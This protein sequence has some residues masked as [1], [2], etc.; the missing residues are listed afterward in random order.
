MTSNIGSELIRSRISEAGPKAAEVADQVKGELLDLLRRSLRPEFLNR[1]DEIIVFHPLNK[2]HLKQILHLQISQLLKRLEKQQVGVKL[3]PAAEDYLIEV[4]TDPLFGARPL[5]R[6]LQREL[7]NP[8]AREI[9]AGAFAPGYVV[10]VDYKDGQLRFTK[11]VQAEVV[12]EEAKAEVVEE[13]TD[14]EED[15]S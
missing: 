15:K 11:E 1:I 10:A 7:I 2:G 3:T 6:A 4:G 14:I 9:L 13:D 8:L 12:E 5:K